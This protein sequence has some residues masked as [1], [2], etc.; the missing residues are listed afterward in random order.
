MKPVTKSESITPSSV[1]TEE[2]MKQSQKKN[3]GTRQ[4]GNTPFEKAQ[5]A[6]Q[7][8]RHQHSKPGEQERKSLA[9]LHQN[10][11][12]AG[13][14]LSLSYIKPANSHCGSEQP[15][16]SFLGKAE[17]DERDPAEAQGNWDNPTNVNDLMD[18]GTA[19][20]V[21]GAVDGRLDAPADERRSW[22]YIEENGFDLSDDGIFDFDPL[23]A[24]GQS[25]SSGP[26]RKQNK[27]TTQERGKFE[28]SLIKTHD[29]AESSPRRKQ[30][31]FL[32]LPSKRLDKGCLIDNV[33][34]E[35]NI[36][37]SGKILAPQDDEIFLNESSPIKTLP[38]L[39]PTS[40]RTD[41]SSPFKHVLG[42]LALRR[43]LSASNLELDRNDSAIKRR[44]LT[45]RDLMLESEEDGSDP[46]ALKAV[47]L[48]NVTKLKSFNEAKQTQREEGGR[49]AKEYAEA[50]MERKKREKEELDRET[51]GILGPEFEEQF[52]DV[53]EFI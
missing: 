27:D 35:E 2:T 36:E 40:G 28:S 5:A 22:E 37:T 23:D 43:K 9:K 18:L 41:S 3:N 25:I 34:F 16:L 6:F 20:K 42:S 53:V 7:E 47:P 4:Q 19:S 31:S 45:A 29:S 52:K 8:K 17:R 46:A 10:T 44:K 49:K 33:P 12:T 11:G 13:K 26:T 24:P 32:D 21:L 15:E 48:S 51:W 14:G 50:E 39:G 1:P 30:H 38:R